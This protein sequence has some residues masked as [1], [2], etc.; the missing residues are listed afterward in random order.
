[1][2]IR[3]LYSEIKKACEIASK[4]RHRFGVVLCSSKFNDD[5][6][7]LA[8]KVYKKYKD[9]LTKLN[10]DWKENLLVVGRSAFLEKA[11]KY[12]NGK[13]IHFKDS[14]NVLGETYSSLILDLTE[15]FQPND[16]GIVIETIA[17]GGLILS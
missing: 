7:S 15:G 6:V 2:T 4:N 16:L 17:E 5:F 3:Q 14:Q 9:Y 13:F 12:F 8:A 10:P 11:E 1:M